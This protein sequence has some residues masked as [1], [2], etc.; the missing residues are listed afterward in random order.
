MLYWNTNYQCINGSLSQAKAPLDPQQLF[1]KQTGHLDVVGHSPCWCGNM[2]SC[3]PADEEE[4]FTFSLGM[5]FL[6]SKKE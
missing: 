2:E 5:K 4:L 6:T 3:E 1:L